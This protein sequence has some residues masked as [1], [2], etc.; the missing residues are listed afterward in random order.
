MLVGL[1]V[2][3]L[4]LVSVRPLQRY[5]QDPL[6]WNFNNLRTEETPSQNMW[7]RMEMLGM[8]QV[9]A[10]YVGNDAVFLVDR[11]EQADLVAEA[12]RKKDAALGSKHVLLV[13]TLNSLL[14]E[15]QDEKL[16]TLSRIR[17]RSIATRS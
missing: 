16:A 11:P 3:G 6:E 14:P 10:G 8:A 17:K 13:R 9:G 12:V 4:L 15:K 2:A 5:L 1:A 7:G